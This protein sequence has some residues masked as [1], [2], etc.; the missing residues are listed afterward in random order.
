MVADLGCDMFGEIEALTRV[1][2]LLKGDDTDV[3][4]PLALAFTVLEWYEH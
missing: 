2:W 3:L 4:R 1:I